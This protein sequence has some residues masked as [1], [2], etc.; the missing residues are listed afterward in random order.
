MTQTLAELLNIS[1]LAL[2]QGFTVFLRVGA[3]TAL[4]PGFGEQAVPVRI[5]IAIAIAFTLIVAPAVPIGDLAQSSQG[6]FW[7]I[8]T[9]TVIGVILG[10]GLRL[11]VMALQMAGSIAAQSTSLAQIL[12]TAVAEPVPAMG[13][14]LVMGGIALAMMLGLHVK[15]AEFLLLSYQMMPPGALPAGEDVAQWGLDQVRQAFTLAFTLAAPFV[16]LSVLYN[17]AIGVIN[18][19]MPQ[20]MVAFV[21]APLI[22]AGGLFLL[23]LASPLMLA[24]WIQ[25]L[26][27]FLSNPLRPVP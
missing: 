20:L 8:I 3:L 21:G 23:C 25:A 27:L 12:G 9:E 7:L 19:A 22:T 10:L 16:V 15:L 24:T 26:N 2:W 4:M 18:K 5:K 1:T 14:I 11:L 6:I 13:H 17:L